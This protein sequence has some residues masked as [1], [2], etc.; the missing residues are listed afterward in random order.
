VELIAEVSLSLPFLGPFDYKVP[1]ALTKQSFVGARVLVPFGPQKKIGWITALKDHS[2][3]SKTRP[4]LGLLDIKPIFWSKQLTFLD[5]V[6]TYYLCQK[7]EVY[8][9]ALPGALKPKPKKTYLLGIPPEDLDPEKLAYL[10]QINGKEISLVSQASTSTQQTWVESGVKQGYLTQTYGAAQVEI[11]IDLLYQL[12]DQEIEARKGSKKSQLIDLFREQTE[13][14]LSQLKEGVKTAG[15][16]LKKMVSA[17]EVKTTQQWPIKTIHGQAFLPLNDEQATAYQTLNGQLG[18]FGA[19]LL[20]GVTGSGKTEVYLHLTRSVLEQGRQVLILL[21]EIALTHQVIRRFTERFGERIAVLHS[22]MAEQKRAQEWLKIRQGHADVVIGARSAI[23]APLEN[24]GLIVVDEEHDHSFKQQ[25]APFYN[26]RDLSLKLGQMHK[27]VVLLGTAT[28][29]VESFQHCQTDKYRLLELNQRAVGSPPPELKIVNLKESAR[30]KGVFYLSEQLYQRLREIKDQGLGSIL[31]LN[32]RGYAACLSCKACDTPVLCPHCDIAMTWHKASNQ[33]ICHHCGERSYYPKQCKACK[34][35]SFGLEGIGTQRVERDL[36]ILFPQGRFLRIDRDTM[37]N[38]LALSQAI[39]KIENQEVDFVIGTQMIAKGHD[40]PN[41]GLVAILFADLSLNIP[42]IRSSERSYQLFAQVSGRA[43]RKKDLNG[44]AWLQTY[45]PEHFAVQAA[46]KQNYLEFF[47][48]EIGRRKELFMPPFVRLIQIRISDPS[49]PK[50]EESAK[51][52][53][54]II[55]IYQADLEFEMLGPE[56]APIS[57]I[58]NRF[59]W[60]LLLRTN[61][62]TELKALLDHVVPNR[63]SYNLKGSGR[64]TIDIDPYLFL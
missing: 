5:W 45:N 35:K 53:A 64:I 24:I 2:S 13:L 26:A 48:E 55:G 20:K 39:Q 9:A 30:V 60:H 41:I 12:G 57:K 7:A 4:I 3:V 59:Y 51:D 54:E 47:K 34:E 18:S 46:I 25:E 16:I 52:F 36:K 17:G 8:E 61:R 37:A 1:I 50:A 10:R 56:E 19:F 32:R 58:N 15:P 23:F 27:A 42:D 44:E 63:K 43:G 40:F 33:L 14:S 11:K 22:Q 29:S 31:F 38:K 21:P 6:A 28:P 49:P 62:P